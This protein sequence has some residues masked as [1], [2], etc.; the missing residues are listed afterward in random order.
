MTELHAEREVPGGEQE[1]LDAYSRTVVQVVEQVGPSV[2]HIGVTREGQGRGR[3]G[4]LPFE[5]EGSG[6]GVVVRAD[7]YVLTNNHVVDGAQSLRVA[8]ADGS[9]YEASVVGRD[10]L[11][12][13]AVVHI[14]ATN[15]P[16][17]A[18]GD[19]S[20]L[21]VGQMAIAIGNPLGLA[22]SVTAGVI[23]AV[24]RLLPSRLGRFIEDVIQTDAA[25]NPGNS[26]GPLV[27]SQGRVIGINTAIIQHAQGIC[28]AIPINAAR[29][30]LE[31]LIAEGRVAR[32]YLGIAGQTGPI[33]Q[34]LVERLGLGQD[35][36]VV[37]QRVEAD[38]PAQRAGIRPGDMVVGFRRRRVASVEE[39]HRLLTWETIG[40]EQALALL[41]EEGLWEVSVYP[42]ELRFE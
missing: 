13:L 9:S 29:R 30:D 15:L 33:P 37:V 27:D 35:R 39:L 25:L 5:R 17:P 41:R 23:S 1:A 22:F 11:V 4:L 10:P 26:G 28:F 14:P 38:S 2:A 16:V 6:S 32:G 3:R 7:G 8:F 42:V 19:S 18:L 40:T 21:R 34:G 31:T 20:T 24:G 36:G 12:D